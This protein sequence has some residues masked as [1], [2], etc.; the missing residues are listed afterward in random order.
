MQWPKFWKLCETQFCYQNTSNSEKKVGAHFFSKI[1]LHIMLYNIFYYVFIWSII[2]CS[3][4]IS[5]KNLLADFDLSEEFVKNPNNYPK[6][7]PFFDLHRTK[8]VT[9]LKGVTTNLICRV[10]R[11]GNHTVINILMSR[12]GRDLKSL[13]RKKIELFFFHAKLWKY[14]ICSVLGTRKLGFRV[15]KINPKNGL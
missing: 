2:Q 8:N 5:F 10:R 15:S 6:H 1:T 12:N 11:L 7:G 13:I 9:A 14:K 3:N 4:K